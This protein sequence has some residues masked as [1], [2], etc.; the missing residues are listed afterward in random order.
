MGG[1]TA[2]CSDKTGTLTENRMKV[3]KGSLGD[4]KFDDTAD[5]TNTNHERSVD[6]IDKLD[7][8][9]I[10]SIVTNILLNS[11]AFENRQDEQEAATIEI[12]KKKSERAW[13][14]RIF[15]KT[16]AGRAITTASNTINSTLTRMSSH[17]PA[18]KGEK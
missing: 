12:L 7:R 2:V 18:N 11:T 14:K 10:D 17:M 1:A 4:L 5:P 9:L 6:V 15:N 3:V 13:W 8:E 16:P